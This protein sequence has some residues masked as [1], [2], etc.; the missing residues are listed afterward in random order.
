MRV[1]IILDHY[2]DN[3]ML[4][5]GKYNLHNEKYNK[6]M[7]PFFFGKERVATRQH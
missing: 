1:M 5:I 4:N 2:D 3:K 6:I 7:F